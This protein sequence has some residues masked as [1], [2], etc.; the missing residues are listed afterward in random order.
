LAF[1]APG[2]SVTKPPQGLGSD[3]AEAQELKTMPDPSMTTNADDEMEQFLRDSGVLLAM[4]QQALEV[5]LRQ[6]AEPQ[7]FEVLHVSHR[8]HPVVEFSIGM[9]QLDDHRNIVRL[10]SKVCPQPLA[11]L[12]QMTP[13]HSVS[14]RL[15]ESRRLWRWATRSGPR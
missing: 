1:A 10:R 8:H 15:W 11:N 7:G 6:V 5:N 4:Q 3:P 13:F 12:A 2:A 9:G 14:F